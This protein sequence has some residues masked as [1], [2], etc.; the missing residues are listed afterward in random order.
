MK[1][2]LKRFD[3]SFPLP[4]Y[5]TEGAAAFDLGSRTEV[6]VPP[7]GVAYLPLNVAVGT[8]EG[9]VLLLFARSSLHKRGLM[10]A[11]GVG[12]IDPDY[13]GEEDELMAAVLNFTDNTVSVAAGDRVLQ[14]I[15][16]SINHAEWEEV[17][18]MERTSRGGFGTTGW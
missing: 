3:S 16:V 10:L 7:H 13:S 15:F 6:S 4:R 18:H 14:G 9:H 11:N 12:L 2:N 8:P 5:Q 17:S 1:I